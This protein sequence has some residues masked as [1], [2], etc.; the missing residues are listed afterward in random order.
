M[1]PT[2]RPVYTSFKLWL[3][4][5]WVHEI[6]KLLGREEYTLDFPIKK[7]LFRSEE[8]IDNL[9][10]LSMRNVEDEMP[11]RSGIKIRPSSALCSKQTAK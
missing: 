4:I 9:C 2:G 11:N 6:Q 7:V 1:F 10:C 3:D 8:L 5:D